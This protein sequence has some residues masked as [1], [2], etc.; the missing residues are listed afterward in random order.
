MLRSSETKLKRIE[1]K[2]KLS[3]YCHE[4]GHGISASSDIYM[5]EGYSFCSERCR[6]LAPETASAKAKLARLE[7]KV[8]RRIEGSEICTGA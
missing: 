1:H 2:R 3:F 8:R 5:R 4:C 6:A 7:S